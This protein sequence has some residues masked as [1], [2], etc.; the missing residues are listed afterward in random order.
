MRRSILNLPLYVNDKWSPRCWA[1]HFSPIWVQ[2]DD[3]GT[4]V[5]WFTRL[6]RV[7][8]FGACRPCN[9]Y[10][11]PIIMP[12]ILKCYLSRD[13][14][15]WTGMCLILLGIEARKQEKQTETYYQ[16]SFEQHV[17]SLVYLKKALLVT[18]KGKL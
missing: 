17:P 9:D 14:D 2:I 6:N 15:N 11:L 10:T 12:S 16:T 18:V 3:E 4:V 13:S 8:R 7:R 1:A 5:Q